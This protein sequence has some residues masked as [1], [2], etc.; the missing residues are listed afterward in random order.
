[1]NSSRFS[2][3]RAISFTDAEMTTVQVIIARPFTMS[4]T[5]NAWLFNSLHVLYCLGV[6]QVPVLI[7]IIKGMA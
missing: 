5:M 7:F 1:V 3:G 4:V 2:S 6:F